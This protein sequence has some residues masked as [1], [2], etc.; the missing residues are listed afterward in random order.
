MV[1]AS[2]VIA[3]ID[4][5]IVIVSVTVLIMLTPGPD[6]LIVMRN[7]LTG[8]SAGGL[9]TSAGVLV[10]N[11]VHIFYCVIGIGLLISQSV[12]AF[13]VLRY[14]G[15]A[16]L[17]YLGVSGILAGRRSLDPSRIRDRHRGDGWFTQGLFNNLLNPKGTLFYLGIFSMVITPETPVAAA[18]ILVAVMM[19]IS[20][21]FWLIFVRTLDRP[22]FRRWIDG[23]QA[24]ISRVFGGVLVFL[25]LRVAF[26]ES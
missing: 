26:L 18:V 1:G 2:E 17:V 23:S 20:A 11:L 7:T 5:L 25:G 8:G 3:L 15:A 13:S 24:A 14:A 16:Y 12:V 4:Q 19:A 6:M 22:A 9:Q 21:G 10:G